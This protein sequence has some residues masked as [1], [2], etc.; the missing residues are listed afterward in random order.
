VLDEGRFKG[1]ISCSVIF[2]KG[3]NLFCDSFSYL[4]VERRD[5]QVCK[6]SNNV[7]AVVR[8]SCGREFGDNVSNLIQA[9]IILV[10]NLKL[11]EAKDKEMT[12]IKLTTIEQHQVQY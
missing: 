10:I 12:Q 11:R 2:W 9:L 4:F 6:W 8:V 7:P 1:C 5:R 3:D